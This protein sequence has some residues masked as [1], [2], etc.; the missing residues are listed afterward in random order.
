MENQ[1]EYFDISSDSENQQAEQQ[2]ENQPI[3]TT[4]EKVD[5]RKIK[6][7]PWR[8]I[9]NEDGTTKY[10]SKPNDPD[11]FKKYWH[12][13]RCEK[14][15]TVITCERCQKKFTFGHLARHL[16]SNYCIKRY[17]EKMSKLL[18]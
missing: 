12:E 7:A 16:K 3:E 10:N 18:H 11:Y 9:T 13:K 8:T 4:S 15:S 17:N 2:T 5:K 6:R 14:E 1:P